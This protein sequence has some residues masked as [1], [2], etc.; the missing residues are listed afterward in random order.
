MQHIGIFLSLISLS[1]CAQAEVRL[2]AVIG[3]NMVL[4]QRSSVA[5]WGW[6]SPAE[7]IAITTSWNNRTDSIISTRDAKW[8]ILVE[9]PA[10]GGPF[11][12][13]LKGSNT[14]ILKN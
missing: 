4:Q 12:I 6:A 3:D 7:K 9:T 14:I 10:A 2:P 5:L 13:T 1:F 11:T 8:K